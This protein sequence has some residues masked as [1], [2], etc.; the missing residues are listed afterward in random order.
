M[1]KNILVIFFIGCTSVYSQVELSD[2]DKRNQEISS[3]MLQYLDI[4]QASASAIVYILGDNG[5]VITEEKSGHHLNRLSISMNTEGNFTLEKKSCE[6]VEKNN[7]LTKYFS[8]GLDTVKIYSGKSRVAN[9]YVYLLI[10]HKGSIVIEYN[11]PAMSYT[12]ESRDFEYPIDDA[13]KEFLASKTL[14]LY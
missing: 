8:E 4:E 1:Y 7:T 9:S 3:L 12:D 14:S 10:L 11:L 2:I 13:L 5:L 6:Y